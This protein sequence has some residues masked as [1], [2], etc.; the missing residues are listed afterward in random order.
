MGNRCLVTQFNPPGPHTY[1][2]MTIWPNM[3]DDVNTLTQGMLPD[4]DTKYIIKYDFVN[5]G[6]ITVP[7]RCIIEFDGGTISGGTINM[8][9]ALIVNIYNYEVFSN[10]TLSGDYTTIEGL[11]LQS[12]V[13]GNI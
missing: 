7:A 11:R 9:D 8:N 10:T 12:F 6:T 13:G 5:T 4:T 3:V 2:T 1:K